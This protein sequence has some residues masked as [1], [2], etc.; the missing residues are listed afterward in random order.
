MLI[1]SDEESE[2]QVEGSAEQNNTDFKTSEEKRKS[3]QLIFGLVKSS[4]FKKM[5][6]I[7]K[8]ALAIAPTVKTT[9]RILHETAPNHMR[10]TIR[11]AFLDEAFFNW[12]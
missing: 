3:Q 8:I 5:T 7:V 10:Q 4:L 1:E 6:Q 2:I 12:I 9:A 11:N